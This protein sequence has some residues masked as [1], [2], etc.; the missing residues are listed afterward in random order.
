MW[1]RIKAF[2]KQFRYD[3]SELPFLEHLDAFRSALIRMVASLLIGMLICLPFADNLIRLLRAPA[4]PYIEKLNSVLLAE[5]GVRVSFSEA[6]FKRS[7][8]DSGDVQVEAEVIVPEG[9]LKTGLIRLQFSEPASAL[10]MWLLVSFFGGLL[11]SLPFL[12]FFL[13][14]FILPGIRDIEQRLIRRISLFSGALFL[15]GV[16]MG[17]EI[18]LPLA[19]DLMLK[20]GGQLGGESIWFYSKYITFSLQLLLAFGL[21]FQLPVVILI[22]GK[23]G[24]VG[25]IQLREKRRHVMVGLLILAM[26]LTP[27]D[28]LTQLLLAAPLILLYEFCIWFLHLTGNRKGK[29]KEIEESED[30]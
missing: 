2:G 26:L 8:S 12:I 11:I 22:L 20:I 29:I 25:S 23:M 5:E 13:G 16:Y 19:L 28:L 6:S 9:Q 10:K 30:E 18:T 7:I 3:E 27:P 14:L 17:Y 1:S 24:L 21:A 4:E 15:L